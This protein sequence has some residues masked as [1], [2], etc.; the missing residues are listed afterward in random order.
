MRLRPIRRDPPHH[1]HAV[2]MLRKFLFSPLAGLAWLGVR[3]RGLYPVAAVLWALDRPL[4]AL[5]KL[6]R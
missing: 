3:E 2:H 1:V 5:L 6:G 4:R